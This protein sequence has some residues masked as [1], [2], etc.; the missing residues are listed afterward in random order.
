MPNALPPRV[1]LPSGLRVRLSAKHAA[2]AKEGLSTNE[3]VHGGVMEALF[4]LSSEGVVTS[5]RGEPVDIEALALRDLHVLRSLLLYAGVLEEPVA[6]LPCE[7]CGAALRVAPS[8]LLEVG[9]FV[10]GELDDP[11]LDKPFEY[12][13]TYAIPTLRVSGRVARTVRLAP[14]CVRE[15]RALFQAE[16]SDPFRITQA[17]CAAMGIVALGRERRASAIAEALMR[18]S[19]A[20]YQAIVDLLYEAHYGPRLLASV[21][22]EACGARSDLDV[23][24]AREI[25]YEVGRKRGR[26]DS[27][28][29]L[30]TFERLVRE[31]AERVFEKRGVRNIDLVVHD[32]VPYCDDG[33][34][35]LLGCY[36]PFGMDE[37]LGI[38]RAP[39]IRVFYRT[40]AREHEEDPSF[41]VEREIEETIDHEVT[42]HLHHLAG[43]DPLDDEEREAIE[44]DER[45]RVGKRELVRRAKKSLFEDLWGFGRTM[46]PLIAIGVVAMILSFCEAAG[47]SP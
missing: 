18:A 30:D 38:E 32:D 29:D 19:A 39:E 28:P 16:G 2:R 11:E 34:E 33:G 15:A 5:E 14:R 22:C 45:T 31:A 8:K 46:W 37:D 36:T 21:R 12:Q 44:K 24:W 6:E 42:H 17:I 10:D 1:S 13:R 35:P 23:P 47:H 40:F 20:A 26:A 41:D 4:V 3:H 25:P 27:F 7:N 43:H 9:P